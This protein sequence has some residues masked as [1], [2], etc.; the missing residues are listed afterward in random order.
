M[1][2]AAGVLLG[3]TTTTSNT[4]KRQPSITMSQMLTMLEQ[5]GLDQ[6]TVKHLSD[7]LTRVREM[8]D[9]QRQQAQA[10]GSQARADV[11]GMAMGLTARVV[12]ILQLLY[13]TNI[14]DYRMCISRWVQ[15]ARVE[16]KSTKRKFKGSTLRDTMQQTTSTAGWAVEWHLW[17]MNPAVAFGDLA[18]ATRSIILTSG[19]LA[20]LESFASELGAAFDVRLE[21]P[22]VVDMARQV[23]VGAVGA[24]P[25][26]DKLTINFRS[27]DQ[28][29]TQV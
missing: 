22:H 21:A 15:H 29:A 1:A 23:W 6:H 9:A 11:G 25:K 19:T 20:P 10:A 8:E 16:R 13:K 28:L 4:P 2:R 27:T 26:G 17:C 7:V 18:H 24:T 12:T 5:A 14:A 3:Y